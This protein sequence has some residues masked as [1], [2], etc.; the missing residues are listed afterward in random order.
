MNCK[1]IMV[2]L[3]TLATTSDAVIMSIGAAKFDLDSDAIDDVGFYASVSIESNLDL[4][5]RISEETLIWWMKQDISAKAV[6]VEP[7]QTLR[8]SLEELADW[9]GE[10]EYF[11]WSNGG[12]FDIPMLG[13][14]FTQVGMD[15]PWKFRNSRCVRTYKNLPGAKAI[16]TPPGGIKHNALS[17]AVQQIKTLQ[18]IHKALFLGGKIDKKA[19]IWA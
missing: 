4:K 9:I 2:D 6:F 13:H 12:D 15:I 1:H 3:E 8:A 5:R 14:A 19:P 17:D 7:K 16:R 18:A 10:G 11:V